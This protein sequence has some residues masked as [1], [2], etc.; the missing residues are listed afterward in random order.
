VIAANDKVRESLRYLRSVAGPQ[1][2]LVVQWLKQSLHEEHLVIE[3]LSDANKLFHHQGSAACLRIVLNTMES[4][5]K[6]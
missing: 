2:E 6:T 1:Y 5:S 4:Q 3:Q